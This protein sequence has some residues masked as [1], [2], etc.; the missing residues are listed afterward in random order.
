EGGF[1][2]ELAFWTD[3]ARADVAPL[4][5]DVAEGAGADTAGTPR[6]LSITLDEDETRALLQDVPRAYRTQVN[7]ALL[8]AL[9]RTISA[10]TG[11]E[12]VLVEMEGHG[13]EHLFEDVDT[14]RTVGWFTS[15][16]P[17]LLDLSG[18]GDEAGALKA[19][20]EQLR[21]LPRRGIGYGAL[22]W[23]AAPETRE[24]LAALPAPQVRFEYLGQLDTTIDP[25]SLFAPAPEPAGAGVSPRWRHAHPIRVSAAVRG[26]RL[27]VS[28]GYSE[29]LHR[30]ETVQAVAERYAEEL[31]ALIAHCTSAEAGGFT[32]SDFPLARL[33]QAQLDR[34]A[35][36]QKDVEDVYPL[37]S[38][39]EGLLFHALYAPGEGVYLGQSSYDLVGR[40]DEAAFRRAWRETL[41]RHPALR[42]GFAWEGLDAPVQVVRR[43]VEPPL[44]REDWRGLSADEQEARRQAYLAGDRARG[45]DLR[46][47]PLVRLALFRTADD[48]HHL[49]CTQHHLVVDG[50]SLPLIFRDLSA[51][52]GA[53]AEGL[54][55]EP[56]PA[57]PY[58]DFVAWLQARDGGAAER[59]WR[60]AMEGFAAPTPLGVDTPAPAA[61]GFGRETLRLPREAAARLDAAARSNGLTLNTMVQGAWALLLSR[62]SGE[63]DVV[64]GATLSGRP[65]E[66]EGVEGIVGL[67]VN[68][69]PVRVR[70]DGGERVLPW[71]RALQAWNAE[72]HE[73]QNTPLT[74]VQ[75]WSRVPAGT[76][77]FESILAFEN[78]PVGESMGQGA[79]GL[80]V[81]ARGGQ[82][83]TS[84]PVA[85]V[86]AGS[87]AG[88]VVHADYQRAR[89]D[90]ATVARMLG[91]LGRLLEGFASLADG[92]GPR[93]SDLTL[94]A[95]EERAQMVEGWNRTERPYPRGATLP[96]LFAAQVRARPGAD[97]LVWGGETFSYAE[98]DARANRL[99]HRLRRLGV[100]P[101]ARVGVLLERGAELIVSLLAVVKAGGCYVPLDPTDP[102]GRLARMLADCGA[103]ALV[104]RADLAAVDAGLPAVRLDA[105]AEAIAAESSD[106]PES[107]AT[108][109]N[110]AYIVYTSGSTGRPKGVMVAHRHVVQLVVETDYVRIQPGDRVAQASNAS[111]DALTFEAWG[112]FL[113]GATL[114]GV[115]KDVLLSPADFRRTLRE[116]RITTLYQT[117]ALLNQLTREQP[118]VFATLREVLFG[119]QAADAD[120]VRR[121]LKNGKPRRLLHMYGPTETTAWCS[122]EVLEQVADD[123][124]TV[125]VGR[126]TGNQRIYLLDR[127]LRP[128]P[129]GVPGEAYV[130]GGGVVRGYLDRPGLTAERFVPDPFTAEPGAR[131]YRTGDRLRWKADGTLEFIG[132][133][134]AQVK[135]RGFRIEPGEIESVLTAHPDVCEARVIV[136]EDVAGEPRLAAYVV[137][138]ADGEALRAHLRRSLP[139]Y[140]V[141]AAFVGMERLPLTPNGKLDVRA[142]PAPDLVCG[143]GY[144][145]PRTPVEEVLAGIW[146]DV[147]RLDRVGIQDSF[148]EVGGHSLL[149]MRIVSRVREA[150]A[151]ELPLRALFEA[152]T[153]AGVA[154]RVEALRGAQTPASAPI[155][156]ADRSAPLPLSFPQERL[157]FLDRAEDTGA[158][159]TVPL[160]VRLGG[161]LDAE[162]L[163]RAFTTVIERHEVL[164]TVF[165]AVEGHARQV[166]L[167]AA[168]FTLPRADLRAL[169]EEA[170]AAEVA[171]LAAGLAAAY[172]LER[173]PLLRA[174]LAR[175]GPDEHVL[176]LN[177]HHIV[178]D[179]WSAGLLVRELGA[180]YAAFRAGTA[181]ALPPLRVQYADYAAWQRAWAASDAAREQLAYWKRQLA[182]LPTLDLS[183]GR[184]RPEAPS[185]RGRKLDVRLGRELAARARAA[186][187]AGNATLF[188]LLLAAFKVVLARH[189]RTRDVVV[190]A[191]VAGRGRAE[192]EPLIGFFINEL[193]LRTDLSGGPTF[194]ELLA[195]VREVT[196]DAY[197]CQEVPFSLLVKE[198]GARRDTG[199]NPLF[200]VMF[201]L[202]NAPAGEV[203]LEG[204]RMS[205]VAQ[206]SEVSV[207]ELCLYLSETPDDVV[208]T[209][210]YRTELFDPAAVESVR[211]DFL[212]VVERACADPGVRV[213]ALLDGLEEKD[214]ALRAER[215]R[216][217]EEAGRVR[218]Q[219][220][221]REAIPIT[222]TTD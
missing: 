210:A 174:V 201:G 161:E 172:D 173:G 188:M 63:D 26:G 181:P 103:R 58:R 177:L 88:F 65:A 139:E 68:T 64:F 50:W 105:D 8:A 111:F 125:S 187:R 219:G 143:D 117:T 108:A 87:G 207:F 180:C 21:A 200:Q 91:H 119:G 97:A 215:A 164:R 147:L 203:P 84:Y 157:W 44:L 22:R 4:P 75:G 49:V 35:G 148:F 109:E 56:A 11:G 116:E 144:A 112:A 34:V 152:P 171:R 52:Y 71:L 9:A 120:A 80:G 205:R 82:V 29:A 195:R 1:D 160:G 45:F 212:A 62:Y 36:G 216:A 154:E 41:E 165:P 74:Q 54:A 57:R 53:Y 220:I 162:A 123:A 211:A 7:D 55:V 134:D 99:A 76:P 153:V 126:P 168:P 28:V 198:L 128:V 179:G 100:G 130:G 178:F 81:V 32:P 137:G 23:L 131:M 107:G 2:G 132:R 12:R 221:R 194:G 141:P 31:R 196:L 70:V 185:Y 159:Y 78:Y 197:R 136:R 6:T 13:R 98:L 39:Q 14:S 17:V 86:A 133:L 66:V 89:F 199:R 37:S 209:L 166:I 85:L 101:E 73:H 204:V 79:R 16:F 214:R 94:V 146:A 59:F 208:G 127:D 186:A 193:V 38:A 93:L 183:G 202:H 140:M 83:H 151:V 51:F 19:V 163:E 206:P 10:W 92:A 110:L 95:D 114:V 96:G 60:G 3:P 158:G 69:L 222:Q 46:Q 72:M 48:R 20:K 129:A 118:D 67:F 61:R 27:R 176:L 24:R 15:L 102:A 170:R 189:A 40:L 213:E 156:A 5:L 77:L 43:G 138:G 30:P 90:G 121:L 150:F 167:P 169:A 106:S 113:N 115:P 47:A 104:T 155:T 192:L 149:A 124:R 182:H 25:D 122:C 184:P 135:I 218:F 175:T 42:T 142:L 145:A 190:G 217:A 191:D 33:T 18:A